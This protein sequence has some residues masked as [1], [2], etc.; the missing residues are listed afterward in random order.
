[1]IDA[2][3]ITVHGF[4][5]SPETWDRL[6]EAWRADPDLRCL[7]IHGFGYP[8]PKLPRLRLSP[9]RI[10]DLNDI[11]QT[12]ATEYATLPA[13]AGDVAIVTHSQGGLI[14]QRFLAWMINEG[15]GRELA[16][17]KTVIMLAC[18]NGGSEYLRSVRHLLG[19]RR[20]PQ[21]RSLGVLNRE[22]ADT[23][24][25]VVDRIV[26]ATRTDD[27]QCRIPFHVYAGSSDGVV[28][29]A[30]AQAAFPG[31]LTL[32]GDHSSILDP[33]A[34]GNRTAQ[35][36]TLHIRTDLIQGAQDKIPDSPSQTSSDDPT[37]VPVITVQVATASRSATTTPSTTSSVIPR[38]LT[39][40]L[41]HHQQRLAL[42]RWLIRSNRSLRRTTVTQSRSTTGRWIAGVGAVKQRPR[43]SNRTRDVKQSPVARQSGSTTRR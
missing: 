21:A 18:P 15:R 14:V 8:S 30:S 24:R 31:A 7:A 36:V 17:I 35:V 5:S 3:L 20:H 32:A 26:K 2:T 4:W 9:V 41:Q 25:T 6:T 16:R 39:R 12:L 43:V 34:P 23:Q 13:T 28:S 37:R 22:V 33:S 40:R 29:A 1:M 11:A 10:P 19:Y 38:T 42:H 27:H